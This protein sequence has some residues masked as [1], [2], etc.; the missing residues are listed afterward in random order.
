VVERDGRS[1]Y[2]DDEHLSPLGAL[3]T[4]PAFERI[5]SPAD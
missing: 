2:M 3:A 4:K 1:F 5:W